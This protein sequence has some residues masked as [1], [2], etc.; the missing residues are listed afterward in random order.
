MQRDLFDTADGEEPPLSWGAPNNDAQTNPNSPFHVQVADVDRLVSSAAS[1]EHSWWEP[2]ASTSLASSPLAGQSTSGT[3]AR[4]SGNLAVSSS[5]PPVKASF[6][7]VPSSDELVQHVSTMPSHPA[8]ALMSAMM[9]S[10]FVYGTSSA[11]QNPKEISSPVPPESPKTVPAPL[12]SGTAILTSAQEAVV[13][14]QAEEPANEPP[15]AVPSKL[16]NWLASQDPFSVADPSSSGPSE[17]TSSVGEVPE[18]VEDGGIAGGRRPRVMDLGRKVIEKL[19][20]RERVTAFE[21]Q[22]RKALVF[23]RRDAKE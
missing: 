20:E 14:V 16:E 12:E 22:A 4:S 19:R 13:Q 9:S 8:T 10:G 21:N 2:Q 6:S 1:L 18:K 23:L 15:P 5:S 7:R 17:G 3:T 11:E